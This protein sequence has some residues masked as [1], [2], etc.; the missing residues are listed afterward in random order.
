MVNRI[1]DR[2]KTGIKFLPKK[3][4]VSLSWLALVLLPIRHPSR[5][6]NCMRR[7]VDGDSTAAAMA[8]VFESELAALHIWQSARNPKGGLAVPDEIWDGMTISIDKIEAVLRKAGVKA[9]EETNR[10]GI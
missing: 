9:K 10:G 3:V 8:A 1:D 2:P 5:K 6:A 4:S 7:S